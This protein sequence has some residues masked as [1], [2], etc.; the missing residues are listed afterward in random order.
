MADQQ[1]SLTR[2]HTNPRPRV[3]AS[4]AA[5]ALASDLVSVAVAEPKGGRQV[6]SVLGA[7][8]AVH[9]VAELAKLGEVRRQDDELRFVGEAGSSERWR[10]RQRG[11]GKLLTYRHREQTRELVWQ[12]NRCTAV[13][14]GRPVGEFERCL[15]D[16]SICEESTTY[17]GHLRVTCMIPCRA[18]VSCWRFVTTLRPYI[19]R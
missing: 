3:A 1:L 11:R 4:A 10:W 12:T 19:Q 16:C 18:N 2:C 15:E 5:D 13:F 6:R 7:D 8:G 17:F 14:S 9:G